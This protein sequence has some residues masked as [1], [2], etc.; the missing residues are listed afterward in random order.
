R[1][2]TGAGGPFR[3]DAEVD[4]AG[5]PWVG[6][7]DHVRDFP[8]VLSNALIASYGE[9]QVAKPLL[10][11]LECRLRPPLLAVE[12]LIDQDRSSAWRGAKLRLAP[13]AFHELCVFFL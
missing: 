12:S 9:A 11:L 8:N 4:A 7:D 2:N 3:E 6:V 13:A 10:G 1:A 5:L